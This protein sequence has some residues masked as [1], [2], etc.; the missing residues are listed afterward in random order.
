M[1]QPKR[2]KLIA[3]HEW[4]L[5]EKHMNPGGGELITVPDDTLTIRQIMEKFARGQKI[6]DEMMRT[7]IFGE[8]DSD[9]FDAPDVEKLPTLDLFDLEQEKQKLQQS[10]EEYQNTIKTFYENK[11]VAK[12]RQDSGDHDTE[13]RSPTPDGASE[14][15]RRN[16]GASE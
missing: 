10:I 16:D 13:Q 9:D 5:E 1:E 3:Q 15:E 8:E 2:I 12:P 4:R 7:P 6:S 14:G 11:N